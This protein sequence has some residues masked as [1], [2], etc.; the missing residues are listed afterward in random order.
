MGRRFSVRCGTVPGADQKNL[1]WLDADLGFMSERQN[2]LDF[3][4][5]KGKVDGSILTYVTDTASRS[6]DER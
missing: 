5:C 1:N 4:A 6:I 3:V 2:V